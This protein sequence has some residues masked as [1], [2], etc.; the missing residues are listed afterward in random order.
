MFGYHSVWSVDVHPQYVVDEAGERKS[1]VLSLE[2]FEALMQEHEN[3]AD[4]VRLAHLRATPIPEDFIDFDEFTAELE[5]E[6]K[7]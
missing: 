3:F 7:L 2:E 5:A 6:G 1:V 4:A